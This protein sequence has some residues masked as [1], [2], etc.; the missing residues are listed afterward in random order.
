M[1]DSDRAQ[2]ISEIDLELSKYWNND[3]AADQKAFQLH[4]D[5]N[6]VKPVYDRDLMNNPANREAV[7]KLR[8]ERQLLVSELSSK[9]QFQE[10]SGIGPWFQS[11]FYP[12]RS[13]KEEVLEIHDNSQYELTNPP[14]NPFPIEHRFFAS[15][16][17][18][19]DNLLTPPNA[20]ATDEQEKNK[21]YYLKGRLECDGDIIHDSGFLFF[22]GQTR[23][24]V[25]EFNWYYNNTN[26][27]RLR[28]QFTPSVNRCSL[29]YYDPQKSNTWTHGL[30]LADLF[31]VSPE[32]YKLSNQI[33]ICA[34]PTGNFPNSVDAFFWQQDFNFDSC[35]QTYDQMV[36]LDDPYNSVNERILALTGSPLQRT[37]FDAKNPMAPLDFSKAPHFD[38]IWVSSLNYNAD[39]YGMVLNRALRYHAEHG[40]QIRI[41]TSD[42]TMKKKD[43]ALLLWLQRGLPN[44]KLQYYKYRLSDGHDGTWVD[45]F[46]RVSHT[47]FLIGYSEKNPKINF[48]VTGGRNIRDSYIF[49][50]APIYKAYAFLK[51]YG[52]GEEPFIYY[53]DFEVLFRGQA[54]VK[55]VLAQMIAF[56]SRD[57]SNQSFRSTSMN[58]PKMASYLDVQKLTSLSKSQPMI[59]HFL[60]LPYFDGYQLEKFYVQMIDSAKK[61]IVISTPYCR[62]SVAI[63]AAFDRAAARGVKV[64]LITRIHLAGDDIPQIAE[65]V[66][67]E[68]VNHLLRNVEIFEWTEP[69]SILHAKLIVVDQKLGFVSGVNLNRRSFLHDVESGVL[70]LHDKTATELRNEVL[71]FIRQGRRITQQERISWI[72]S[73]L[74]DWADNYF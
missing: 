59:R 48:L 14:A 57:P 12:R 62:P 5:A 18:R 15:Y 60:S 20:D 13:V 36:N 11:T 25:Y 32:W 10:W 47:K 31:S 71:G 9:L 27:Q 38:I 24:K 51:N 35:P 64:Q 42:A 52:D 43:R 54:F 56:W 2:R 73:T 58:I 8:T 34:R 72:N 7:E 61:E 44:V 17:L 23:S 67:K 40:T 49:K 63:S 29:K 45:H 16:T 55:T 30:Q 53:R 70:I 3:W 46:H 39:F 28:V 1:Q 65:D 19:L 69:N 74:I 22:G 33:D 6:N 4:P 37:D 41:L 21:Q 66:N 50:E 26:G 68:G